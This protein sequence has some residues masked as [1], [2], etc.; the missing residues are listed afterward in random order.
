M[1]M[2]GSN[3]RPGFRPVGIASPSRKRTKS[4]H[5]A[6]TAR[7]AEKYLESKGVFRTG[8]FFDPVRYGKPLR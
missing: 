3:L 1:K 4:L 2:L 5:S 8:G 7:A 6:E